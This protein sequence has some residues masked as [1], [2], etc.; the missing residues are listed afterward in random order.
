MVGRSWV[1]GALGVICLLA[2]FAGLSV[3]P[4]SW[5]GLAL[6]LIGNR[7]A[8]FELH[9]P[10]HLV[11][12]IAGTT[13]IILGGVFLL[14]YFGGPGLPGYNPSVSL[15]LLVSLAVIVGLLVLLM[16]R[17]VHLSHHGKRYVSPVENK[18]LVGADRRGE[19]A[20]GAGGR[21]LGRRRGLAGRAEGRRH[22][23]AGRAL[24]GG[25]DRRIPVD[26]ASHSPREKRKEQTKRARR[27]RC[28]SSTSSATTSA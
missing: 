20:P 4:F 14:G 25:R 9:A 2:A 24:E 27:K 10:G 17:E 1:P 7:S 22:G 15:W 13:S 5:A 8:G 19:H 18:A 12:G 6:I 28:R 23:R 26:R 11:F 16:A 21:G 3:L